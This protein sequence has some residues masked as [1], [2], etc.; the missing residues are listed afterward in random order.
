[1]RNGAGRRHITRPFLSVTK[2]SCYSTVLVALLGLSV[3]R[4]NEYL[5][6]ALSWYSLGLFQSWSTPDRRENLLSLS[7]GGDGCWRSSLHQYNAYFSEIPSLVE[8]FISCSSGN[9]ADDDTT[10]CLPVCLASK[11]AMNCL[12]VRSFDAELESGVGQ[13]QHLLLTDTLLKSH[14]DLFSLNRSASSTSALIP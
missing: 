1:M 7:A 2:Q 11:E 6:S 14:R 12:S 8:D 9:E 4:G 13:P 3:P 5:L 10:Q